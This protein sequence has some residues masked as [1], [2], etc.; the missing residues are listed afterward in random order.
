G[1]EE[2]GWNGARSVSIPEPDFDPASG[3]TVLSLP[4]LLWATS[5]T[6][7]RLRLDFSS[8]QNADNYFMVDWLAVGRPTPGASQA[9]I[10]DLK[11]AMTAA[12][13][14]EAAAR[15]TLAVQLRGN[16]EGT[17]PAKLVTGIIYNERQT[18]VT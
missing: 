15:N 14:A 7:R 1:T 3:V 2:T 18:R 5:G 8:N 4:D 6:L 11:T 10:Q 16:Y 17:D 9:Q 12:D 13:S